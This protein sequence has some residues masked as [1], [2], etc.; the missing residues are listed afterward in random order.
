MLPKTILHRLELFYAVNAF[1]VLLREHE[2]RE[3][4]PELHPTGTVCH[5][6][7]AGTVPVD[8]PSSGVERAAA[9]L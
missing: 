4:L 3:G 9:T 6:A 2:A 8:L 1:G 5:P 7:K